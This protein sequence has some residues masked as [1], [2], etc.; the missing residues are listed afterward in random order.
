MRIQAVCRHWNVEVYS[1]LTSTQ[2]ARSL[3]LAGLLLKKKKEEKHVSCILFFF[4][5]LLVWLSVG[6]T[7]LSKEPHWN[8][9]IVWM[10][11]R[12][13]IRVLDW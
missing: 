8:Q 1:P 7:C 4:F 3:C 2:L 11:I 12:E 5:R 10:Q 6:V 13:R 9:T